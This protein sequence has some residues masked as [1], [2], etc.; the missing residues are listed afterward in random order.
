MKK[1]F[2]VGMA[3]VAAVAMPL[4]G[5][6]GSGSS[7]SS[8]TSSTT[9][10]GSSS[11]SSSSSSD[12]DA[13]AFYAGQWRGSVEMTGQTVY[14]TAGGF[15]QMLDVNLAE[16]GTCEVVPLE[17]HADLLTDTGTWEGTSDEL[18][19]HL[20]DAGDITLTVTSKSTLEGDAHAF[21]I[22]DFDTIQ[23]DFYG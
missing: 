15:E 18:T 21:E 14:G 23:F 7:T 2:I 8:T 12:F 17:A 9:T 11:S 13:N 6:G 1:Q 4:V 3:L 22:A 5:C 19:L 20:L 16:D 10:S